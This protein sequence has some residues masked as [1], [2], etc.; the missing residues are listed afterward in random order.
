[1]VL[2]SISNLKSIMFLPQFNATFN[3]SGCTSTRRPIWIYTEIQAK[4]TAKDT[5]LV[6]VTT[7]YFKNDTTNTVVHTTRKNI[8]LVDDLLNWTING[9]RPQFLVYLLLLNLAPT[10]IFRVS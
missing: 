6:N 1:M 7:F 10:W 2:V 3:Q 9:L 4:A 8:I 5:N